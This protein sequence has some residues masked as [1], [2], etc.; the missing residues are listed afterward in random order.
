LLDFTTYLTMK[1]GVLLCAVFATACGVARA[2]QDA[3]WFCRGSPCPEYT[4]VNATE[5]YETREYG[6]SERPHQTALAATA[7]APGLEHMLTLCLSRYLGL[8]HPGV[9]KL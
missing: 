3:P 5:A 4:V 9:F 8:H 1:R 6:E 7:V 2:A